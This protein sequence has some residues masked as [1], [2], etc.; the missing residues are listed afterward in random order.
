MHLTLS[1]AG[2]FL[3]LVGLAGAVVPLLPGIPMIFAGI[4]LIAGADH[5][6]HVGS[7]WLIGLACVGGLGV[8][9][10]LLAA[11]LGAKRVGASQRAVWGALVGTLI[12]LFFGLPGLLLGPFVGALIGELSAGQSMQRSARVGIGAWFGLIFGTL[13]K[14]AASFMMVALFSFAWWLNRGNSAL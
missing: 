9:L 7:G 5:Y 13:A 8:I 10:D 3:I 6:Q 14:L 4:W 12:G 1:V 11:A 2:A